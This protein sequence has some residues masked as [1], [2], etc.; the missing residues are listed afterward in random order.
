MDGVR[1][2]N[3]LEIMAW[4]GLTLLLLTLIGTALSHIWRAVLGRLKAL[5]TWR[6]SHQAAHQSSEV[7]TK[8]QLRDLQNES[9]NHTVILE[10]LGKQFEAMEGLMREL[11]SM[12]GQRRRVISWSNVERLKTRPT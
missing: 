1:A 2:I 5:E 12:G 9:K 7:E 10:K 8:L 11:I 4:T 6:E 3:W